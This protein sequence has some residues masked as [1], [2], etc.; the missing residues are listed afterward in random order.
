MDPG[1]IAPLGS[2]FRRSLTQE[3]VTSADLVIIYAQSAK[4]KQ[5][6]NVSPSF[7]LFL[8]LIVVPIAE[9]ASF[10]EVGGLL[11]LWPTIGLVILT[12]AIGSWI[13]R[14]Q[15]TALLKTVQE[16]MASGAMP[17][18]EVFSG[19]CLLVAGALLLT[20][21]FITDSFGFL[22]LWPALRRTIY[23]RVKQ[24]I[25]VQG[26]S[27]DQPRARQSDVVEGEFEEIGEGE[28]MPPPRGSW[29]R[30]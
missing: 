18:F 23:Q 9:V 5:A 2:K 15:G 11:G 19:V 25:D 20:P 13:I 14:L 26:Q 22:L 30:R 21:G 27:F 10:I 7:I 16:Q 8:M 28:E 24:R 4:N 29:D 12:A 17:V 3:A 1:H 6:W